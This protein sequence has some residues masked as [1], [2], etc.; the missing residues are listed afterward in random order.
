[1][2]ALDVT[3]TGEREVIRKFETFPESL[4]SALRGTV[5]DLGIKLQ[6]KVKSEKLS[7]Q[8]LNIRTGKLNRSIMEVLVEGDQAISSVV[9]SNL[10]APSYASFWEFGFNGS[11]T[12]RAHLRMMTTAFGK[13]VK[14]PRKILVPSYSKQV[15]QPARSFLRTALRDMEPEI[16]DSIDRAV[17]GAV[18]E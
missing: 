12:I 5:K 16:N 6:N 7:G 10:G 4:R 3:V 17:D 8:V 18:K 14:E 13:T 1:M 15:N 11:Q 9:W 2:S